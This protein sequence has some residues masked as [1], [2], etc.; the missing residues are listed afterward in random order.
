MDERSRVGVCIL[1]IETQQEHLLITVTTNRNLDRNL[2]SARPDAARRFS[3]PEAALEAVA[4]F[5]RAFSSNPVT[6]P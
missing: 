3:E 5:L 6:K 2:Y 4:E 1:R